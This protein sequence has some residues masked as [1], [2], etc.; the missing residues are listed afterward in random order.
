MAFFK[1]DCIAVNGFNNE[2][3]GWGREDS[4]FIVRMINNNVNRKNLRF[5][6]IQYHLWHHENLRSSLKKNDNML[7]N[8]IKHH[9]KWCKH[10]IDRYL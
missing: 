4:E 6:A 5:N 10:G 9:I 1:K 8:S 2:F 3:E 7:K